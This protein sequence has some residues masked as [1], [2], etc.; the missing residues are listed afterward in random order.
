MSGVSTPTI[1][2]ASV[3]LPD[4]DSPTMPSVCPSFTVNV[5][6]M[7]AGTVAKLR[8]RPRAISTGEDSVGAAALG[9]C[10]VAAMSCF[11]YS[12]RGFSSTSET[13]PDSTTMPSFITRT[14]SA[15]RRTAAKS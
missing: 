11:V 13:V 1:M 10:I 7:T 12:C 3:V 2:R 9:S 8:E 4:P 15:I 14:R 6:S 5:A